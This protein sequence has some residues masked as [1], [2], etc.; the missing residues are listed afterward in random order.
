MFTGAGTGDTEVIITPMPPFTAGTFT[1]STRLPIQVGDSVGVDSVHPASWFA[2][3][4]GANAA[5]FVPPLADGGPPAS[6]SSNSSGVELLVNADVAVLPTSSVMVPTCTDTTG[7]VAATVISDPD[8]AVAPGAIHFRIDGGGEQVIPTTGNPG[9]AMIPVPDGGH[10]LEYWGED[11]VGGLESPHHIAS[12]HG[13]CLT[14]TLTTTSPSLTGV[15]QS[16]RRWR[17]GG[18]LASFAATAK[19]PVGT[20]FRFTLN[21]AATVRFAFA[22]LFRGREVSGECV[23][24][25]ARKRRHKACTRSAARGSL[26]FSAGA[27]LHTLFFQ[28][29]L[30]RTKKLKPGTYALTLTA[31]NAAGQRATKILRSFTIVPG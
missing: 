29:R 21:E 2:A 13:R 16:H 28:G 30:T 8:P 23:A 15:S 27:G 11:T 12:V 26:S 31:T 4:T 3:Q 14:P 1:F 24:Q 7:Q 17:L 22:Q 18:K 6:P 19:P 5:S 25:T 9:S 10:T 20:T